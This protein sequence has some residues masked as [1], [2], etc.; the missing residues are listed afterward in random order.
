LKTLAKLPT[1]ARK[2][3]KIGE[4][5][6]FVVV[7]RANADE[8]VSPSVEN[9]LASVSRIRF[10]IRLTTESQRYFAISC[11]RLRFDRRAPWP[12]RVSPDFREFRQRRVDLPYR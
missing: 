12:R 3:V 4:R 5:N 7:N 6:L 10:E 1:L 2:A 8:T 9:R 11:R